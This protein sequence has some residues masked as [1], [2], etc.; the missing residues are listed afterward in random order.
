MK[1]T[2]ACGNS[3]G[4]FED[5]SIEMLGLILRHLDTPSCLAPIL[6]EVSFVEEVLITLDEYSF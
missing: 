4:A 5:L 2:Y 3:V 6:D 1:C